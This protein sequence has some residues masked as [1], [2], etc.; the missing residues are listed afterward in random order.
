MLRYRDGD[1]N[2]FEMLYRRYEKPLLDFIYRL[3]MNPAEAENLYQETFYRVIRSRKKYKVTAQFKTWLFQIAIN[4]CRDRLRRMKH[5]SHL[6]LNAPVTLQNSGCVEH[7]DIVPDPSPDIAE[8]VESREMES[9]VK[10]AISS[11]PEKEHLVFIMK[12]Y[13][14]M[15]FSEIAEILDYPLGTLLSLNHRAI[16]RLKK[17]L[18]KYIGD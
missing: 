5:R 4:L 17:M 14:G 6:S 3:V 10:A 8:Q 18:S 9:L 16:E 7:Q 1:I 12:E 2:A 15:K 11:L 13:Q